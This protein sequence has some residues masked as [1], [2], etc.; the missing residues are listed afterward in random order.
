[1]IKFF[2]PKLNME[3]AK[4]KNKI[5]KREADRQQKGRRDQKEKLYNL[6]YV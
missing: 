2:K 1:M 5:K 6:S 4:V 3:M